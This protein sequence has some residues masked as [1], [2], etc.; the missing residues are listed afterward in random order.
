MLKNSGLEDLKNYRVKYR[1]E[2]QSKVSTVV[3]VNQLTKIMYYVQHNRIMKMR[4]FQTRGGFCL[5]IPHE[6]LM[7]IF[8]SVDVHRKLAWNGRDMH[9]PTGNIKR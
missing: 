9:N 7:M 6:L 5:K 8:S 3:L 1:I 2:S 4:F